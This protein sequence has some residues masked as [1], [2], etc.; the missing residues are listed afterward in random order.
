ML[1]CFAFG[2]DRL[3]EAQLLSTQHSALSTQAMAQTSTFELRKKLLQLEALYDIGRALNTLRPEGELLE[4][5]MQRAVATLDA[6]TGFIFS[7]D[8]RLNVQHLHTLGGEPPVPPN[9]ILAEAPVK[10]VMATRAA[11]AASDLLLAPM[12]A[13]DQIVGILAQGDAGDRPAEAAPRR[14]ERPRGAAAADDA[15]VH[16]GLRST[17]GQRE[18]A[19][20]QRRIQPSGGMNPSRASSGGWPMR[21]RMRHSGA[22]KTSAM[23]RTTINS[24]RP[25]LPNIGPPFAILEA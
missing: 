14:S 23:T 4:E 1:S 16:Y 12:V 5:L 7:L 2:R 18:K 3:Q 25:R 6:M 15:E 13:G 17:A 22:T 9:A 8:E 20:Y 21:R 19:M 10:Q 24:G 11:A